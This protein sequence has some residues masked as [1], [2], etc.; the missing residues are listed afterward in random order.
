MKQLFIFFAMLGQPMLAS[1][2]DHTL[3]QLLGVIVEETG[4]T[5]QVSSNGCTYRRDFDF[6]VEERLEQMGP[7]LP[8]YEHHYYIAV[9]RL[10]PDNC[11]GNLP[12]GTRMFLSFE[13]LGIQYGKYHVINPVGGETGPIK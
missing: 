11:E 12:F 4:L 2:E 7:Q 10:R 1:A 6:H 13:E 8:A 5:F 3:E 9:R